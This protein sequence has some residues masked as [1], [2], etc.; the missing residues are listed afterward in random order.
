MVIGHTPVDG[1]FTTYGLLGAGRVLD[2]LLSFPVL[3]LVLIVA[4]GV[5]PRVIFGMSDEAVR[6]V[7]SFL[8]G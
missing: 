3:A 4:L 1:A 2:M 8:G 6:G 5:F 7:L